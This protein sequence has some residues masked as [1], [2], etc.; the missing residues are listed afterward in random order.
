MDDKNAVL[1]AFGGKVVAHGFDHIAI[2]S[3]FAEAVAHNEDCAALFV[4]LF[5]KARFFDAV[6]LALVAGSHFHRPRGLNRVKQRVVRV[7]GRIFRG[8]HRAHFLVDERRHF[9]ARFGI[10][11]GVFRNV[12][13]AQMLFVFGKDVSAGIGPAFKDFL[14]QLQHVFA[15]VA[16]KFLF[17]E[18]FV[19]RT[20]QHRCFAVFDQQTPVSRD[21]GCFFKGVD[22]A[23]QVVKRPVGNL[24]AR[25]VVDAHIFPMSARHNVIRAARF[26]QRSQSAANVGLHKA[27]LFS[28]FGF[29]FR[30]V[31]PTPLHARRFVQIRK[32]A[33][34]FFSGGTQQTCDILTGF[35]IHFGFSFFL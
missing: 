6:A 5:Q 29:V 22:P 1:R 9:F 23:Q 26:G 17:F 31:F 27:S 7:F 16:F 30:G 25:H 11:F 32:D 10:D 14:L 13:I 33:D 2:G 19:C 8:H 4:R 12:D 35:G 28:R 24:F 15:D 18:R 3:V 20:A 34:R 21:R